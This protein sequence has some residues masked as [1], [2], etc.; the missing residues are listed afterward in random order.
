MERPGMPQC[1]ALPAR[2]QE[3]LSAQHA[4]AAGGLAGGHGHD[5]TRGHGEPGTAAWAGSSAGCA[6]KPAGLD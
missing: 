1:R 6:G 3:D 4:D 5:V 2:V